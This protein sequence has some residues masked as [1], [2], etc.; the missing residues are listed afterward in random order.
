[1]TTRKLLLLVLTL[2]SSTLTVDLQFS[3][4]IIH[5]K[6]ELGKAL[7]LN[8]GNQLITSR[9]TD[10]TYSWV[11]KLDDNGNFLLD[12][13]KLKAVYT[14]NA[15]LAES[16]LIDGSDGYILYVKENG[17]EY[18]IEFKD[19]Q[20]DY[21]NKKEYTTHQEQVSL[22]R[23][24]SGKIFFMGITKP[25]NDVYPS[26]QTNVNLKIYDP[27]SNSDVSNGLSLPAYSKYVTCAEIKDNEVYCAYVQDEN[28]L[29]TVLK[30]QRFE[31]T[32][33]GIV[34]KGEPYLIKYFHTQINFIKMIKINTNEVG[35]LVQIGNN[36]KA[37]NPK[38]NSGEDLFFYQLKVTSDDFEVIR[39]DFLSDDCKFRTDPAD[40]HAD[41]IALDEETIYAICEVDT[42]I[43]R[44][45]KISKD[46]KEIETYNFNAEQYNEGKA[47]KNPTFVK[48][49]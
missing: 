34:T 15:Q 5:P 19:G 9:S 23:L 22:L 24:K 1:M 31:I 49:E 43:M 16:K 11:S 12:K 25:S 29:R 35:I 45:F 10:G 40:Y 28:I 21:V 17:K 20:E 41:I 30:L 38:G 7:E 2:I 33:G 44:S 32:E 14:G 3:A 4:Q 6:A 18:L 8:N 47:F 27:I 37:K 36:Q 39:D 48:F 46:E 42:K 26:S 13:K